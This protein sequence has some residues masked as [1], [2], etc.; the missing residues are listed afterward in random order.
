M[1][2]TR[3]PSLDSVATRTRMGID[4]IATSF[5]NWLAQEEA[6]RQANIRMYREYHDG[7]QETMLT[8][9]QAAYLQIKSANPDFTVN[10]CPLVVNGLAARLRVRGF[11]AG[12]QGGERGIFWDWWKRNRMDA[13]QQ[14]VHIAEIRDGDTYVIVSWDNER[15]I[16][17]FDHNLAFDGNEGVQVHYDDE[18]NEIVYAVKKWV[19]RRPPD[20]GFVRRMNVYE[21]DRIRR[22]ISDDRVSD[23][24]WRLY[25]DDG[26]EGEVAWTDERGNPLGVPVVHFAHDRAGYRWGTSALA[27]VVPLQNALNKEF[28]SLLAAADTTGFRIFWMLGGEAVDENGDPIRV[29]PGSFI[30][31][32][33]PPGE[34]AVGFF[35]GEDLRPLNEVID[36]IKQTIAQITYT[37]LHMFQVSG[38]NASEGAQKQQ[39]VGMIARA[40]EAATQTGNGW[41][42][43]MALGR[44]LYN[45]FGPGKLD[46]TQLIETLWYDFEM[47]NTE[48]RQL[49]RAQ[50]VK[51]L[52]EAGV[53]VETAALEAGFSVESAE[54][55]GRELRIL[56][57]DQV[58]PP[59]IRREGMNGQV[60]APERE[61]A[62]AG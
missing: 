58:N 35:P 6:A 29:S 44:R 23:G 30:S 43:V 33:N 40:R 25:S 3:G 5:L 57:R 14:D 24:A 26:Q 7:D 32:M 59:I 16:P 9:R 11:D 8:D 15:Q 13:T 56:A 39:E 36:A 55:M 47:R 51:T 41:E 27:R 22:F 50:I 62:S 28:V 52:V 12:D 10:F 46:E 4:D 53:D 1:G 45:A 34:G 49:Q 54:R 20:A 42:D 38:Q 61:P 2:Y 60:S 17:R 18:T 19:V 37:P 31:M 48:D 21:P